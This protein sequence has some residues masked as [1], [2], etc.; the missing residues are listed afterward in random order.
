MEGE[1]T[2]APS[3]SETGEGVKT[4][5]KM[6]KIIPCIFC[7]VSSNQIGSK[8]IVLNSYYVGPFRFN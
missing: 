3:A 6:K 8:L 1:G 4:F 5:L 2:D 7:F